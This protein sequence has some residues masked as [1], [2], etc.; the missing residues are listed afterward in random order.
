VSDYC[1]RTEAE[2]ARLV[3]LVTGADPDTPVTTCPGWTMADLVTHVGTTQRWALHI[4]TTGRQ[5]RIWSKDVPNGLAEGERG[6]AAWLAAGAAELVGALRATD[7]ATPLWSWGYA[8]D[9]AWWARRMACELLIHRCD[10]EL[11]LGLEPR[12]AVAESLDAIGELL[13][14]LPTTAWVTRR[15]ATLGAEGATIHLHAT[16]TTPPTTPTTPTNPINPPTNQ[17]TE[18]GTG[19]DTSADVH[20][21][22]TLTQGPDGRITSVPGHTK[23][24][25]AVQGPAT[26]LLLM[27]YGRRS[28]DALTVYGDRE[29][30]DRWLSKAAF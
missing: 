19:P 6:D 28:P 17:D 7:P 9:A 12:V 27:L 30:L 22:W 1:A 13:G 8:Q 2:A 5:E 10:A 21:E 16:D 14:N 15:L 3:E 23:A 20:G 11:A 26:S 25:V 4:V 24:D 29:W 18:P